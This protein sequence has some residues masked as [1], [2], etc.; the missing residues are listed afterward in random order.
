MILP[1]IVFLPMVMGPVSYALGKK[2]K[3]LRN[4]LYAVVCCAVCGLCVCTVLSP[5]SFS[6]ADFCAF[7]LNFEADGFRSIYALIA[8]F[9]WMM[10][11]FLSQE[12]FIHYHNRNRYYF[13]SLLTLGATLGVLLSKDLFTTFIFFEVMSLTSYTWVAHEETPQ[14]M[15]AAGTYLTVAVIG[16]LTTLMG[17]FMLYR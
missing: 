4:I 14:A 15:K 8:A 3:R 2:S 5:C 13:F 17:L 10:T 1:V 9:M 12:Y 6:M 11:S 7:G 16:G